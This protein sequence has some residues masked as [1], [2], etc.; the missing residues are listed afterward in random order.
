M[1]SIIN[2]QNLSYFA[3]ITIFIVALCPGFLPFFIKKNINF[4]ILHKSRALACGVFLGASMLHMLPEASKNFIQLGYDYPLTNLLAIMVFLTLLFLEHLGNQFNK[5]KYKIS[6]IS[7]TLLMLLIHS[8]LEGFALGFSNR[9]ISAALLIFFA[10]IAHKW[11]TAFALAT[12]LKLS[13]IN[14]K[15]VYILFLAFTLMTPLGII[16]GNLVN[17]HLISAK[18]T[19]YLPV[20]NAL[21]GGT[22][23][24]IGT[25]HGL[26]KAVIIE[27]CCNLKEFSYLITG[28]IIMSLV[29]IYS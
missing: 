1:V 26:S 8:L 29:A 22:F 7:I 12:E 18:R 9:D 27:H 16:I 5:Q 21:T 10:I 28:F 2:S 3:A 11:A 6:L 14:K 24:Y 25:L 15:L 19:L 20:F 13:S 4:H 17:I 23:L